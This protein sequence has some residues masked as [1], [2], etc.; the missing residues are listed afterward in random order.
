[1][2]P[3]IGS[4]TELDGRTLLIPCAFKPYVPVWL[5]V[6][7]AV[8]VAVSHHRDVGHPGRMGHWEGHWRKGWADLNGFHLTQNYRK[9]APRSQSGGGGPI[10]MC[11]QLSIS[12]PSLL[13]NIRL[14]VHECRKALFTHPGVVPPIYHLVAPSRPCTNPPL[15]VRDALVS[16][17]FSHCLGFTLLLPS[18]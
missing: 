7:G 8:A 2:V 5:N 1:M 12:H 14:Q 3:M 4:F 17:C 16:A 18:R 11:P 6:P 15:T 10:L 9:K 13:K